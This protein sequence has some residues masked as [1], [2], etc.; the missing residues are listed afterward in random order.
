MLVIAV[1]LE[2]NA[3]AR[4]AFRKHIQESAAGSLANEPGC[5]TYEA[6]FAEGGAACF[7]YEVYV[8]RP[9]FEAH[10]KTEHFH[11][12]DRNTQGMIANKRVEE[13]ELG[14]AATP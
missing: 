3:D 9:A 14:E 1:R 6:S 5:I 2:I 7:V 13:Y 10:L 8:D 11:T 4:E 12:F